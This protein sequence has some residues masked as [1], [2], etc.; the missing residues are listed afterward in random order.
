[1]H[2]F[3]I[4][5][6]FFVL[7]L[8]AGCKKIVGVDKGDDP[9]IDEEPAVTAVGVPTGAATT[10]EIGPSGGS[11]VS[12]DGTVEI[13][14]PSGA[15]S[16]N[17]IF[18]IQPITNFCPNGRHAFRLLPS[19]SVFTNPVTITFHYTDEDIAGSLPELQAIAYQDVNQIWYRIPSANI[20]TITKTIAVKTKHFTDWSD[21]EGLK[22]KITKDAKETGE[23][24]INQQLFLEVTGTNDTKPTPPAPNNPSPDD[25]ELPPLPKP[26]PQKPVWYINQYKNGNDVVGTLKPAAENLGEYYKY[27][28]LY[29]A[30][31]K[32]PSPD[33]VIAGAE[34][35]GIKWK[36]KVNGKTINLNKVILNKP[37]KIIG[38]EY[39]YAVTVAYNDDNITG[40]KG[41]LYNDKATFNMHV[42]VKDD[43]ATV[44][45]YDI[46][47]QNATV[48][49]VA[50]T[51][52][53]GGSTI[54]FT[55]M[56]NP[57]TGYINITGVQPTTYSAED[58]LLNL[59][60]I[61]KGATNV[62]LNWVTQIGSE[63]T[64]GTAGTGEPMQD[65]VP[66]AVLMKL[67]DREQIIKQEN[68]M[69]V[70]I[71]ITPLPK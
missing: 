14:V 32:V 46:E 39:D 57:H 19:G 29:T 65:G 3:I 71:K 68:G 27:M 42:S 66:V 17:T 41:Q 45:T 63:S 15:V 53:V 23:V 44:I 40:Y 43:E 64:S 33:V 56:N 37:I 1:M 8:A 62:A 28:S 24:K 10:K 22:L 11:I 58:S 47:N 55:W 2:R 70:Y 7:L 59:Q 26:S 51:Y 50:Q 54:T 48:T 38:D 30:P 36:A 69:G 52:E 34:L 12:A 16:A 25:D 13:T 49:P 9:P 60:F 21:L 31:S 4:G 61:H 35:T 18:T 67:V 20:D 6:T 5:F